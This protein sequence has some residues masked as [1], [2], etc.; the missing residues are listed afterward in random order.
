MSSLVNAIILAMI[1][2]N[3]DFGIH[4]NLVNFPRNP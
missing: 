2:E 1:I 3:A 4:S